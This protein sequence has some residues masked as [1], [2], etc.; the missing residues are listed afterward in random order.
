MFGKKYQ[1]VSCAEM[2]GHRQGFR[3]CASHTF[4]RTYGRK[5]PNQR[6]NAPI[7]AHDGYHENVFSSPHTDVARPS[8]RAMH[9]QSVRTFA[10]GGITPFYFWTQSHFSR[11]FP[12]SWVKT[13]TVTTHNRNA[14]GCNVFA[15]RRAV[16][17][18][19]HNQNADCQHKLYTGQNPTNSP[20]TNAPCA[21]SQT[22]STIENI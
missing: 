19:V 4:E 17:S 15:Q 6:Q 22:P 11:D 16:S 13:H 8:R 20:C 2:R 1:P 12:R 21:G 9:E 3:R 14:F 10:N 5:L 18:T 7:C